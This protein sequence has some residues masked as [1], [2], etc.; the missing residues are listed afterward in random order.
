MTSEN[1]PTYWL[2]GVL[3]A[4][5]LCTRRWKV[6][7]GF[8]LVPTALGLVLALTMPQTWRSQSLVILVGQESS[9]GLSSLMSMAGKDLSSLL[10]GGLGDDEGDNL[11]SMLLDSRLLAVQTTAKFRLDTAW[12]DE[13]FRTP[14]DIFWDWQKHFR[15]ETTEENG[16]WLYL[17]DDHQA[18]SAQVLSS[19]IQWVD[20]TFQ[21][22]RRAQTK[23]MLRFV[24][25]MAGQRKLLLSQ[26]E[27]SLQAFQL[28]TKMVAP[29]AQLQSSVG[30]VAD[31]DEQRLRAALEAQLAEIQEGKVSSRAQQARQMEQLLNRSM[32]QIL[33]SNQPS[34]GMISNLRPGIRSALAFER[35]RRE[36]ELHATVYKLMVQQLE[37]LRIEASKN[38]PVLRVIEPPAI[39]LKHFKPPRRLLVQA[40]FAIGFLLGITFVLVQRQLEIAYETSRPWK[41]IW[42]RIRRDA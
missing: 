22:E 20:S 11:L 1:R 39:P 21:E 37:Q 32:K 42:E 28:R 36:V 34:E 3:D 40:F 24:E 16:Y 33:E 12:S 13:E 2:D 6:I 30:A 41:S 14:E 25:E 8:T 35:L 38:V 15:W 29:A 18:R 9:G 26:A 23:P 27:D 17:E 31:L 7:L 19:I 4:V 10:G 5:A